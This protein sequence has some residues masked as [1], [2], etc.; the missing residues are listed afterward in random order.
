ME[1]FHDVLASAVA[2][3]RVRH[4]LE[5]VQATAARRHR[6]LLIVIA[7][8]L[9]ALAATAGLA[10]YAFAQKQDADSQRNA[11]RARELAAVALARVSSDPVGALQLAVDASRRSG[12]TSV[13]DALR[14]VLLATHQVASYGDGTTPILSAVPLPGGALVTGDEEGRVTAY[15]P[16]GAVAARL[17]GTAP[18]QW[19]GVDGSGAVVS[20]DGDGHVSV[21]DAAS[22]HRLRAFGI[23]P[24][25]AAAVGRRIA[26]GSTRA[27]SVYTS[28]GRRLWRRPLPSGP[29]DLV[30]KQGFVLAAGRRWLRLYRADSGRLVFAVRARGINA[31]DLT[32]RPRPLVA[33]GGQDRTVRLWDGRTGKQVARLEGHTGQVLDVAFDPT[34]KLLASASADEG[35]RVWDV[36]KRQPYEQLTGHTN[37]VLSVAFGGP[38][39]LLT[40]SADGTARV[41][42]PNGDL[43]ATLTGHRESVTGGALANGLALTWSADGTAR[44]WRYEPDPVIPTVGRYAPAARAVALSARGTGL[45]ICARGGF[46]SL[47]A[48]SCPSGNTVA[49]AVSAD[50]SVNAAARKDGLIVVGDARTRGL[51]LHGASAVAL[52]GNGALLATG[53]PDGPLR[54]F[55][56]SAGLVRPIAAGIRG[57]TAVALSHDGGLVAAAGVNGETGA[58][59]VRTGDPVARFR[60]PSGRILSIAFS[61]DGAYVATTNRRTH[62]ARIWRVSDGTTRW[63]LGHIAVVHDATFSPDGRWI[64]TAGPQ[65]VVL[66]EMATGKQ[67]LRLQGGKGQFLAARFSA[68]GRS[69]LTANSDGTLGR[70]ECSICA[71]IDGLHAQAIDRLRRLAP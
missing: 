4:D 40:T 66:W 19:I 20:V 38:G 14:T 50:G 57:V 27:L 24:V 22:W 55:R 39:T 6:R 53:S 47:R 46:S 68:D 42:R 71:G 69:I 23:G 3:W 45:A 70:W 60:G 7:L 64:V 10:V 11:G 58:W 8:I 36:L 15:R 1:I 48:G 67:V 12:G 30:A 37:Q 52:D 32:L 13:E 16:D 49:V 9:V 29:V 25:A 26:V 61:A 51:H 63:V 2:D 5:R 34:G 35:A 31:A 18:V 17:L 28:R 21:W 41:W 54:I 43:L 65:R 56:T 62:E 59:N 44:L 33:T